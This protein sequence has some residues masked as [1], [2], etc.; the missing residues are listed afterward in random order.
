M[1]QQSQHCKHCKTFGPKTIQQ[2]LYLRQR[3]ST[4]ICFALWID[5]SIILMGEICKLNV[6]EQFSRS[7][8]F[9]KIQWNGRFFFWSSK[10][11]PLSTFVKVQGSSFF[12]AQCGSQLLCSLSPCSGTSV[13][14]RLSESKNCY[15]QQTGN[16]KYD[17]K[18]AIKHLLSLT[19]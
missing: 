15:W 16:C 11:Q 17:T 4:K 9:S 7:V 10:L 5:R 8:F 14:E 13:W 19:H 1:T 12:K 18:L 3:F 6:Q 2:I